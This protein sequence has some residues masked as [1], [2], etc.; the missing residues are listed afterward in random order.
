MSHLVSSCPHLVVNIGGVSKPCLIDTG[1]MVS[2]ITE[3]YFRSGS[4][5]WGQGW[6]QSC[7]WLQRRASNGLEIPYIGYIELDVELSGR[8]VSGCGILV[9]RDQPGCSSGAL[10]TV[11]GVSIL[12]QNTLS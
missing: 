1:S 7:R 8:M 12:G 10:R 2:T 3:S 9:V 6:L 11:K 5:P 4:E